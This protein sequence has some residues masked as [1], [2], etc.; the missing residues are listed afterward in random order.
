MGLSKK[1]IGGALE[2]LLGSAGELAKDIRQAFTG[3]LSQEQRADLERRAKDLQSKVIEADSELKQAQRD[4]IVAEA[5]GDSWL[6]RNWRPLLMICVIAIIANNYI[7][8]PYLSAFTDKVQVLELPKGLWALLNIG[9]GGYI[10]SR[11]GEKIS[12]IRK[13]KE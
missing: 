3:E 11:G 4:I 7:F 10:A 5:K 12:K 6:Q 8:V 13:G 2:G 1:I 9:V